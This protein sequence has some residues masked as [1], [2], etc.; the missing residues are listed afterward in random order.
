MR[1]ICLITMVMCSVIVHDVNAAPANTIKYNGKDYYINGM[2]VPWNAFGSDAGTHYQWGAL[3]D[4]TFFHT[5]FQQC[6]EYGVNCVRLWIHCDGRTSPEFDDDGAVS[7]LDTN[8]LSNLEDI[9]RIGEEN[10]VM[11][12]PCLWS[13]DMTKDF[14]GS[15]GK[16]GGLHADLIKDSLKTVS[17]INNAL[18]PMVKRFANTCN[19][20]AWEIINEPEWSIS[21]PGT[22]VQ[23]VSKKEMVRFCGMIAE[24][25]HANSSKM[26][27]VGSACLK[28]NSTKIGPAEA[29]YWSDSSFADAY[30]KPGSNLD[31]YQIHYY[32]WMFNAEWG[33]DPFQITKTPAYWNLD[34]PAL[35]GENPGVEGKYTLKQMIDNAYEN[36]YAGI[37]PWS[38]DSVDNFGSWNMCKNE[39]KAFH[40]KHASL[41]DF[42]CGGTDII[43]QQHN[44]Q[45]DAANVKKRLSISSTGNGSAIVQNPDREG[46][47]SVYTI[48]G[49]QVIR[50]IVREGKTIISGLQRGTYQVL[51]KNNESC[52]TSTLIIQ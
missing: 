42:S 2:N 40:D 10:N 45:N 43:K 39:L 33:Y 16:Y 32:D 19:L 49:R 51:L 8:F 46:I 23:L 22:T 31:F 21:G 27:T 36:G 13:F 37:M 5:L 25:I 11:V 9:F 24:A 6:K 35:I 47:L 30:N 17:Y 29:H 7:G 12:M 28:W 52:L 1:L 18:V 15:A 20:F 48:A 41:I 38:Y 50:Q 3:Y 44:K 4:S 14:T 34:K 26:V